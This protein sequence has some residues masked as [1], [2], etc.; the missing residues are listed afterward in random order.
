MQTDP[1]PFVPDAPP[2]VPDRT[3]RASFATQMFNFFTWMAKTTVGG[4]YYGIVNLATTTYNNAID[5]YNNAVLAQNAANSAANVTNIAGTSTT[6]AT[7][8]KVQMDFTYVESSRAIFL[9]QRLRVASRANP[10]TNF[11]SGL[12]VGW[13]SGTKVVSISVDTIG[14]ASASASD[15]NIVPDGEPGLSADLRTPK[16]SFTTSGTLVKANAGAQV[17]TTNTATVG[18]LAAAV[19]GNGWAVSFPQAD[20]SYPITLNTTGSETISF[21]NGSPATSATIPKGCPAILWCDATGFTLVL[22]TPRVD[23]EV[24]LTGGNGTGSTNTAIA[25]FT[26]AQRNVG[27]DITYADSATLGASFTINTPGLY[28][29]SVTNAESSAIAM[30]ASVNSA[31]LTTGVA[32]I[33]IATRPTY[34]ANTTGGQV[35]GTSIIKRL[36]AGDVV[37]PH[38]NN[39]GTNNN[40]NSAF[41]ISKVGA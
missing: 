3:N 18:L 5:A 41:S 25:R 28:S 11:G 12:V 19:L 33:T 1:T 6:T 24:T 37:R 38:M 36:A 16:V 32:A 9:G 26:T 14:T 10:S 21:I 35:T 30:G 29:I 20:T 15:W 23:S 34:C 27:T 2:T 39:L 7:P 4:L 13:N 40:A 22:L 17:I 31:Q 8:A